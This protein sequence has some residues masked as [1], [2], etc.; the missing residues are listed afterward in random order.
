[1]QQALPDNFVDGLQPVLDA[2]R[3][4][5]SVVFGGPA[6][7]LMRAHAAGRMSSILEIRK[8]VL[9]RWL[10]LLSDINPEFACP[11]LMRDLASDRFDSD[12]DAL[13][14]QIIQSAIHADTELM[15]RLDEMCDDVAAVRAVLPEE[16]AVGDDVSI[17]E[18]IALVPRFGNPSEADAARMEQ[19][20][21]ESAIIRFETADALENEFTDQRAMLSRA[22]PWIFCLGADSARPGSTGPLDDAACRHLLLQHTCAAAHDHDLVFLLQ[23]Q[24]RRHAACRGAT[25]AVA[26]GHLEA[27]QELIEGA[28]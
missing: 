18:R 5:L 10:T 12:L 3:T 22:F 20:A 16:V 21:I 24:K 7:L 11:Q 9:L 27:F 13:P 28:R 8:H 1:V 26:S 15:R 23:D 17:F 4:R 6:S 19:R 14:T 25:A 2:V